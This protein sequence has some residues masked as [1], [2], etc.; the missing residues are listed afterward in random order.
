MP[1]A[2]LALFQAAERRRNSGGRAAAALALLRGGA[3]IVAIALDAHLVI[4]DGKRRVDAVLVAAA[5][6]LSAVV[7]HG[8]DRRTVRA[9]QTLDALAVVAAKW[10]RQSA[11]CAGGALY[12]I[13]SD[14]VAHRVFASA[15]GVALTCGAAFTIVRAARS[16]GAVGVRQALLAFT[17]ARIACWSG[18]SAVSVREALA[19]TADAVAER[20]LGR[21]VRIIHT[22]GACPCRDIAQSIAVA[23]AVRLACG[24]ALEAVGKAGHPRPAIPGRLTLLAATEY[25]HRLTRPAVGTIDAFH[26][27]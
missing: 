6:A 23:V 21:A 18:N 13:T 2:P 11:V 25:A 12:A 27:A 20:P 24:L 17:A 8:S 7:T 5:D 26:A 16:T 4:A 15:V 9:L 14:D 22:L 1:S 3:L 10:L 19:A